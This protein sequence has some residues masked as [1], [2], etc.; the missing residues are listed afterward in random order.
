VHVV[1][2]EHRGA[3]LAEV[4]GKPDEPA[5]GRVHRLAC[6]RRLTRL[7]CERALGEARCADRQLVPLGVIAQRLEQPSRRAPGG[8]LLERAAAGVQHERAL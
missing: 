4:A 7:G 8:V 1:D 2:D 5:R 6:G 3:A